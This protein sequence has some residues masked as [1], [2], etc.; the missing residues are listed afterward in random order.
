[1]KTLLKIVVSIVITYALLSLTQCTSSAT[2]S[3]KETVVVREDL[4]R[5]RKEVKHDLGAVAA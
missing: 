5:Q 4:E 3:D 1:M 2:K